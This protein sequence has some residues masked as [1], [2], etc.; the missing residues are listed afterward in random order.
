MPS[1]C[2][3]LFT[4]PCFLIGIVGGGVQLGPFGTAA[5]NRPIVPA[6]GDNDDGEIGGMM[7]GGGK[8]KYSEKT[9]P[10]AA[11]STIN[12]TCCPE[13]NP[14][15]RG[16]KPVT[17]RL[18]YGT[19]FYCSFIG[20]HFLRSLTTCFGLTGHLQVCNSGK[21]TAVRCNSVFLLHRPQVT[22]GF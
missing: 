19:A 1:R 9:G 4:V 22:F 5:I 21:A 6:P 10:S 11:L 13:A 18:S 16:G 3:Y 14:G 7:I 8:P 12:P 20:N 17:N 2:N 15:R